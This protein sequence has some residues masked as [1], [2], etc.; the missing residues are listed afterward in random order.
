MRRL[1]RAAATSGEYS[2]EPT[3]DAACV[4]GA[5]GIDQGD[6]AYVIDGEDAPEIEELEEPM[7]PAPP[8]PVPDSLPNDPAG[9][10]MSS[11]SRASSASQSVSCSRSFAQ[12]QS[13]S[14]P[15]ITPRSPSPIPVP[16]PPR[17]SP[18]WVRHFQILQ[19]VNTCANR[20]CLI[21]IR[22]LCNHSRHHGCCDRRVDTARRLRKRSS[23]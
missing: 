17:T 11:A 10:P 9:D 3:V 1:K 2:G 15:Q 5:I 14:R 7:P 19:K 16:R 20:K 22:T 12:Q 6:S 21:R 13:L 23:R 18:Y 8:R 4:A